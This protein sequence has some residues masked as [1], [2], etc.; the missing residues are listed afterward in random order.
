MMSKGCF[1][2]GRGF[3]DQ[4]FPLNEI[5]EKAREKRR[6]LYV[7]FI[8][9]EKVYDRVNMEALWQA[10]R[11]YDVDGKPFSGIKSMYVVISIAWVRLKGGEGKGFRIESGVR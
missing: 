8:D 7:D 10:L 3:V 2:P 9:Q 5:G 4:I 6:M 1:R 11:T